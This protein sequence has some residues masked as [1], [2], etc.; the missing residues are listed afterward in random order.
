MKSLDLKIF[1]ILGILVFSVAACNKDSGISSKKQGSEEV[2]VQNYPPTFDESIDRHFFFNESLGAEFAQSSE[3]P[4]ALFTATDPDAD[5]ILTYKLIGVDGHPGDHTHFTVDINSG[6]I[7]KN[8]ENYD[9][10][11][12]DSYTFAVE[13]SDN[14]SPPQLDQ[15][16]V[17]FIVSDLNETPLAPTGM[18]ISPG[19]NELVVGWEA[20]DNTGRPEITDYTIYWDTISGGTSNERIVSGVSTTHII[21]G[22]DNEIVYYVHVRAKNVDGLGEPSSIESSTPTS[23]NSQPVIQGVLD[24][25]VGKGDT[26]SVTVRVLDADEGDT[27]TLTTQSGTPSAVT[28]SSPVLIQTIANGF[29]DF[30]FDL[31]GVGDAGTSSTI[32]LVAQDSSTDRATDTSSAATFDVEVVSVPFISVWR[33]PEDDKSIT[34][35]LR[36]GFNYNF[37]VDWGDD[38]SSEVTSH[39]DADRTHFY[40]AAG[41]YTVIISGLVEA[42]YFDGKGDKDKIISVTDLGNVGWKNLRSAFE[43]CSYL[44]EFVGGDVSE[45]T[46]MRDMFYFASLVTP[47]VGDWDV[48]SVTNMR[49]LFLNA[50]AANPDV[51][52]WNV[53]SVTNMQ[54]MFLGTTSANPDVSSW[55]VSNVTNMQSMFLDTSIATPDVS[56]WNVFNVTNMSNMF[57]QAKAA[58]PNVSNWNVSNVKNMSLMFYEADSATP[59]VSDWDVSSVTNMQGLFHLAISANPD[60]SGWDVSNVSDMSTMFRNATSAVPD[61]SQWNLG[62][63]TDMTG[64][65]YNLTIPTEN[66]SNLLIQIHATSKR[67]N[68]TLD[69]GNS[70]YNSS[71]NSARQEL[72]NRGWAIADGGL[73]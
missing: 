55:D 41:N 9:H 52:D 46:D 27:I 63:V 57:F 53:S 17:T 47:D 20:P 42:W 64:M 35:P 33:V 19:N 45:V 22:L 38:S 4:G 23:G 51:S 62:R 68:V 43:R 50:K 18:T 7:S 25:Q 67:R 6:Q 66:Y 72:I 71:A 28:V 60:V 12:K 59:N 8:N 10:E 1:F 70:K 61:M 2:R 65:F 73:E 16:Q 15:I 69:A 24:Q 5:N 56:N 11:T 37:T 29:V 44:V 30:T 31:A 13:V 36:D 39:N 40:A 14:A 34:L 48:S 49:G 26:S 32:T 58:N 54:S 21:T 3:I